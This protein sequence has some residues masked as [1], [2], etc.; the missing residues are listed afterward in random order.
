MYSVGKAALAADYHGVT[1]GNTV[2]Q[3]VAVA[4]A[5]PELHFLVGHFSVGICVHVFVARAGLFHYGAVGYHHVLL[6]AE[7]YA[8]AGEHTRLEA[9]FGVGYP[10]FGNECARGRV[11]GGV[12]TLHG[13]VE[14]L[15]GEGVEAY[16]HGHAVADESHVVLAY[17]DE[18]F[19]H[20]RKLA[21]SENGHRACHIAGIVVAGCYHAADR[22]AQH[23]VFQ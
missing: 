12:Y 7:V 16:S 15:A 11:D 19:H 14:V 9:F 13:S 8:Y 23:S 18:H 6:V 2:E 1:V 5:L 4:E 3:L 21:D 17:A 10:Y 20:G 22:R